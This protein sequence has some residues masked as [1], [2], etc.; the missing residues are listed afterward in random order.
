MTT[1]ELI[2][3]LGERLLSD[4]TK[5]Y[6]ADR[7]FY[8]GEHLAYYMQDSED[9]AFIDNEDIIN[10]AR[11]I[12]SDKYTLLEIPVTRIMEATYEENEFEYGDVELKLILTE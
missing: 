5:Y 11:R 9:M 10:H 1:H 6:Q 4:L 8:V 3:R 7:P 12:L 2:Q